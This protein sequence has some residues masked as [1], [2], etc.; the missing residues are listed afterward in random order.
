MIHYPTAIMSVIETRGPITLDNL[1]D[2]VYNRVIK[3]LPPNV[4]HVVGYNTEF[5]RNLKALVK[6]NLVKE[7]SGVY[8]PQ[9]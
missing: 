2:V 6:K 8:S 4:Y 9:Y 1:H 5:K 3:E 7:I